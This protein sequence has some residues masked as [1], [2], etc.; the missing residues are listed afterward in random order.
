MEASGDRDKSRSAKS[1]ENSRSL[2]DCRVLIV[3]ELKNSHKKVSLFLSTKLLPYYFFDIS[4][5]RNRETIMTGT[6][7]FSKN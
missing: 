5:V 1:G 4:V 3:L 2:Q 7:F 6:R